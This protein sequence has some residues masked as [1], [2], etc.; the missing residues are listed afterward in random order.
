[1]PRA[2]PT[3]HRIGEDV[4]EMLDIVPAILRVRRIHRP[5]YGCRA[6]ESAVVQA[7]APRRPIDGGLPT[8]CWR[9]WPRRSSTG[10]CRCITRPRC[11]R[12]TASSW[13][14]RPWCTGSGGLRGGCSRSTRC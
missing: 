12:A 3:L 8:A 9:T 7:A 10:T 6:C 5:R 1:M 13:T 14:A 2:I 4:S 11:W